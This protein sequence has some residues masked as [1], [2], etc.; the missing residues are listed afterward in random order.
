MLLLLW[1]VELIQGLVVLLS[2]CSSSTWHLARQKH[3]QQQNGLTLLHGKRR[4]A[5]D[6]LFEEL[7]VAFRSWLWRETERQGIVKS[8]VLIVSG[9]DAE[10]GLAGRHIGSMFSITSSAMPSSPWR[11]PPNNRTKVRPHAFLFVISTSGQ[12]EI[13]MAGPYLLSQLKWWL[14]SL[15]LDCTEWQESSQRPMLESLW[16]PV[17]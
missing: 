1:R 8:F 6:E 5:G 10:L 12:W 9:A 7:L 17:E 2:S 3:C 14:L 15:A 13:W 4:M 16:K 11:H